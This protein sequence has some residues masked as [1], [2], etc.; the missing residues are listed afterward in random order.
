MAWVIM[1]FYPLTVAEDLHGLAK[2]DK[3]GELEEVQDIKTMPLVTVKMA[4]AKGDAAINKIENASYFT[5]GDYRLTNI[6]GDLTYTSPIEMDGFLKQG[7]RITRQGL[8]WFLRF[9]RIKG[10]AR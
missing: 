5:E 4:D 6:N 1:L 2:V 7:K 9:R 3:K 10:Q 8:T